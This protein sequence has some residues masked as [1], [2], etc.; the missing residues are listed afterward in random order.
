MTRPDGFQPRHGRSGFAFGGLAIAAALALVAMGLVMGFY[1]ERTF[2]AQKT[3][4][5]AVQAQILAASVTAALAFDDRKVA[6][7]YVEAL[8]ANPEV[9]A[10][11]VYDIQG[12]LLAGHA[13]P[14][15]PPPPAVAASSPASDSRYIVVTAPVRQGQ[16]VMGS[17]YMR[18]VVEPLPRRLARY[19]GVGLLLVM[20]ALLVG[21]LGAGQ[22]LLRRANARLE[23]R[24]QALGEANNA[25]QIHIQERERAEEALRQGQ[26]MEAIGKL[27]G[28]LAHDFNNLLMVASGGLDILEKSDDPVKRQRFA[29]AVR[30]ALDR[31]A[32]LTG[33]LLAF[34]RRSPL[35][36][37][38]VD[39][40]KRIPDLSILLERSLREDIAVE[41]R[42]A[43]D[44]WP[45]EVDST[46]LEVSLLNIAVN[47][48]DA[49][50]K[51]GT[52][53]IVAE[54][55]PDL[56]Q[57]ELVG[58]F[59]R[60]S[61]IDDGVGMPAEHI[62]RAFEPFFT[63]KEVGRGTGLGLSQVYGFTRAS[64]GDVRIESA[65]GLGTVISL[66]LPR[67]DKAAPVATPSS[68]RPTASENQGRVLLVEDDDN[69]AMVVLEMLQSLAYQPTRVDSGAA[70]LRMLK[71]R[72]DF[73]IV[74]S[75]MVMP[76][77]MGGMDLAR[78]V[79]QKYPSLPVVLTTGFSEAATAAAQAGFR[80]LPKP[81]AIEALASELGAAR[82]GV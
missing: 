46:Q 75:D 74:F 57:G 11:G 40:S 3:Q 66:F 37:E 62:A 73:D 52:L 19:A 54:N 35:K 6:Q 48:R 70:A 17:V 12:R 47:A 44:L 15:A 34:S 80:V 49:M 71:Q 8:S 69:V 42:L 82:Q 18:T 26:K 79:S 1:N 39:L 68:A 24:A 16:S 32:E 56:A 59:V 30:Q 64:G 23:E 50:A 25:L 72:S 21:V 45:I 28:G 7:E 22:T 58:D 31:G 67:S 81:Y 65:P 2:R 53:T 51:G 20:A 77:G 63:T 14:N 10:A 13:R 41:L 33:K 60:L 5:V 55:Q 27:T 76:G 78:A 43:K 9:E 29:G 38:I 36:P 61:I 4:E